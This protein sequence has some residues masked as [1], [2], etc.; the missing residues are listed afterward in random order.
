MFLCL[1]S[2]PPALVSSA[3]VGLTDTLWY[4][5]HLQGFLAGFW[6]VPFDGE[7][8]G[9]CRFEEEE[10]ERGKQLMSR[11]CCSLKRRISSVVYRLLKLGT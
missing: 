7:S 2:V 9:N 11:I 10:E 5:W 1:V 4:G 8:A 6:G 3:A